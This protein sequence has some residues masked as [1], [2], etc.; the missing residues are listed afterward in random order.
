MN[1]TDNPVS[2]FI[3]LVFK[4]VSNF[5]TEQ[6][7]LSDNKNYNQYQTV[8]AIKAHQNE[9]FL[10]PL[11]LGQENDREFYD[12]GTPMIETRVVNSDIDSKDLDVYAESN[13]VSQEFVARSLLRQFLKQSNH[14]EK[15]NDIVETSFDEGNIVVRKINGKYNN[16]EI[17]APVLLT[18]LY[19]IDQTAKTLEDTTVVEKQIMNQS[20]L[21]KMKEWKNIDKVIELG[22]QS[23]D[24]DIPSYEIYLRFGEVSVKDYNE[25]RKYL[26]QAESNLE[27]D[28]YIQSLIIVA[29]AKKGKEYNGQPFDMDGVVVFAEELTPEIIKITSELEII[30]YK[31]YDEAHLGKYNGRWLRKGDREVLMPYQNRANEL[32]N[33]IRDVM[34]LAS[35]LIFWSKDT[36]IAGKNII[37]AIKNGQIISTT[38]LEL[39]NNVFPNLTFFSEEWN[40]N[41]NEAQ[42]ALKAFEV[43]SG[44]AMPSSTSATAVSVQNQQVGKYYDFKREKLGL[45]FA[46]VFK[47]WVIPELLK[48]TSTKELIEI[49][50]DPAYL[51]EYAG[52][53]AKGFFLRNI[54]QIAINGGISKEE[55]EQL[56]AIKK[57]EI[58]NNKRQLLTLEKD[59]FKSIELYVCLNATG[60]IFNKQAKVS[61]GIAIANLL[62]NPNLKNDKQ[63]YSIILDIANSLGYKVNTEQTPNQPIPQQQTQAGSINTGNLPM[64]EQG[65]TP[66]ML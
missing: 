48:R 53:L 4:E 9:S 47:R 39:L 22:N 40:R 29:K 50:G 37:S 34:R 21:R 57:Q 16:G 36:N 62:V 65:E 51:D 8:K 15:I 55:A 19:V 60:E 58:L 30:K 17:Y 42:K 18:N 54:E 10:T 49:V 23:K 28:N 44:E 38:H 35:K 27:S 2:N 61:N 24:D 5:E 3:N 6:I 59:F 7:Q 20:T 1:K 45:F 14:G 33:Q 11:A 41:L 32:G 46:S 52:Y 26:G 43:A 63:A 66:N 25:L 56:I 13:F 12:I 64:M 31:P